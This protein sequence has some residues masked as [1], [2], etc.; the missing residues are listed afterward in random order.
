M[1]N[2]L[3]LTIL[4]TVLLTTA[5]PA[6]FA[7]S[8]RDS[9]QQPEKIMD[10]VGIV[11]GMV[12]GEAGAGSGYFTFFLSSRVGESGK[13]YANDIL[14]HR[15]DSIDA[16]CQKDSINNIVTVLGEIDDP[17][18]P[19]ELDMVIMMLAFHEF[20]RPVEWMQNVVPSMKPGA[21]LVIIERDPER[22]NQELDH[23]MTRAEVLST[24]AKTAFKLERVET[25]LAR[26]NIYIFSLR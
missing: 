26:D 13:V 1:K 23:Y 24:M 19:P 9:W 8:H 7:Q 20:T 16:Q 25:F 3:L 18:F 21:R 5:D 14:Q 12:I 22:T 15:L 10:A 4:L 11:P 2:V 17:L 6:L